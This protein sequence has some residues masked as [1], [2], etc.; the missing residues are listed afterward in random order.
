MRLINL[1]AVLALL[2]GLAACTD[3]AAPVVSYKPLDYSYL[4]PMMLKVVTVNFQNDYVPDPGAAT[5]LGEDPEPPATA[6]LAMAQHRL[7][8]NG[9]PGTATFTVKNAA[10]EQSGGLLLGTLTVRVDVVS[11]DGRAKGFTEASVTHSQTAPDSDALDKMQPALYD[12][13]KQ[14]MDAMNVQLQY[15]MQHYL[16][17]WIAYSNNAAAAPVSSTGAV[18]GG[19]LATPLDTPTTTPATTPGAPPMIGGVHNLVPPSM[20]PSMAPSTAH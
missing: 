17:D 6:V 1:V 8:A 20:A 15:Q 18:T 4:P 2:S 9:T 12:M 11:G 3:Q 10:I 5:L 14:L 16:G 7:V 19:I 13:T